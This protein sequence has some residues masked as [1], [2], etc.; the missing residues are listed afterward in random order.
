MYLSYFVLFG[1]LYLR[2]YIMGTKTPI[3]TTKRTKAE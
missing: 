3:T 2:N 1:L